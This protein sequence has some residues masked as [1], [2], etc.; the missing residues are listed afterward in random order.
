MEKIFA[1]DPG[2]TESAF[3][4]FQKGK[5]LNHGKIKNHLLEQLLE[6][7]P[8]DICLIEMFQNY[9]LTANAG[10]SVFEAC[11]W[12]GRFEG[13]IRHRKS[14]K[15]ALVYRKTIVSHHT[16]TAT[17][18]DSKVRASLLKK[19]PKGT[20]KNPGISFG[21]VADEWQALALATY[22]FELTNKT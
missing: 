3:V 2:N 22:Y 6:S 10:A 20:T 12:V 4:N 1:I 13:V 5:I 11:R 14:I 7:E 15:H 18:N 21:L 19:Y 9:G 8:I 17:A 16:G